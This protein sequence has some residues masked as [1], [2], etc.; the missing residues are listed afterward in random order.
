VGTLSITDQIVDWSD[1]LPSKDK[2]GISDVVPMSNW[3]RFSPRRYPTEILRMSDW[4]QITSSR[5]G[6]ITDW[7]FRPDYRILIDNYDGNYATTNWHGR[8]HQFNSIH[9]SIKHWT[10]D[11]EV[12]NWGPQL[13]DPDNELWGSLYGTGLESRGRSIKLN[14]MINDRP[15]TYV[16]QFTGDLQRTQWQ[17]GIVTFDIKDKLRELPNRSFVYDYL[18]CGSTNGAQTWGVVKKIVGTQVM[19]DDFGDMTYVERKA[20]GRSVLESIFTGVVGGVLG[21][22]AGGPAGAVMG[23]M[24]GFADKPPTSDKLIGGYYQIQ[25]YNAIPDDMVSSGQKVKFYPGSVCGLA[26]NSNGYLYTQPEKTIAGGTFAYGLYGTLSFAASDINGINVGDYLYTRRPLAFT[27]SPNQIIKSILTG[28]NIDKPYGTGGDSV[29]Y[30]KTPG[31]VVNFIW[32]KPDFDSNWDTEFANLELVELSNVIDQDTSPFNL[33]KEIT[34]ETQVSFYIN[35]NNQFVVRTVRPRGFTDTSVATYSE[36]NNILDGFQY[37]RGVDEAKAG[38]RMFY[39]F[40]GDSAGAAYEGGFNKKI[41]IPYNT[42]PGVTEWT[43][44]KSKW[45]QKDEDAKI[46]GWRARVNEENGIDRAILP[47][48]LFGVIQNVTDSIRVSHRTGSLTSRLFEIEGY[49]KDFGNNKVTLQLIDAQ[50]LYGRGICKWS[51]TPAQYDNGYSGY[52]Y[53]GVFT[54][55]GTLGQISGTFN[56]WDTEI[57]LASPSLWQSF[58]GNYMAFGSNSNNGIEIVQ[59]TEIKAGVGIFRRAMFNTISQTYFNDYA[60]NLGPSSS[61]KY[62]NPVV[63]SY[64]G[65]T[66]RLATTYGIPSP[67]GTSFRFF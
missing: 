26:T 15:L 10:G 59:L 13:A 65:S 1:T 16:S 17:N 55:L 41:E 42:L 14:A 57:A 21:F 63:N 60:Y 36:G 11:L 64:A 44:V 45:I 20:K 53:T 3:Y 8:E 18:N 38:F 2:F 49:D 6:T 7:Q 22:V 33:I 61:D 19:I 48:T 39:S 37:T 34:Q 24:G 54:G 67:I 35:E 52:S 43:E 56:S 40:I 62:G 12:G 32:I 51:G 50:R 28:S 66:Y 9:K 25:D 30:P 23:F 29:I 4:A 46:I 31:G 58:I 5:H 47:T 27:G